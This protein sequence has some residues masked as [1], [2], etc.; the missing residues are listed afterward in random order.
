[1]QVIDIINKLSTARMEYQSTNGSVLNKFVVP[2]FIENLDLRNISHSVALVGSRGSGKSTYI[3]YF[4][5]ATRF[6]SDVANIDENELDCIL[7]Y[8]KPDIAYCQ[9]LKSNWLKE[10]ALLFFALHSSLSI[11]EELARLIDNLNIHYNDFIGSLNKNYTFWT[12]VSTITKTKINTIKGLFDWIDDYKYELSTRLN[13]VNTENLLSIQP[14]SMLKYLTDALRKD[15]KPLEKTVFKIFV[16]EFELLTIEQ[17]K[18]INTYRKESTGTLTWNVAYKANAKPSKD[19]NSDQ[20]LQSP[21]DFREVNIDDLIKNDYRIFA[22]EIFILTLRNAGLNCDIEEFSPTYLGARENIKFRR[23][24]SYRTSVL[25]IVSKILPTPSIKELSNNCVEINSV[26]TILK[27]ILEEI[28]FNAKTIQKIYKNPSIAITI[29]GT[30]KQKSFNAEL[31]E[32]YLCEST[33]ESVSKKVLQKIS[34][35]EFNTLLSLN[36]QH[37]AVNVPVYAGFERFVTMTTPNIRHFKELCLNALRYSQD[38][39]AEVNYKYIED[40]KSISELGMHDG[41][42]ATSSSLVKEVLSYP[43]Y[44]NRLAKMVNRI[45]ELFKISQKSSYQSEPERVIFTIP[46]DYAGSDEDLE[47]FLDSALSWRVL[48]ID[49]SKRIK[50]DNQITNKEYQLNPIYSPRFGISY[51]KKRGI[52][53]TVNE[54]KTII[55]GNSEEFESIKKSYQKRWRLDEEIPQQGILL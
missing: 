23:E 18:T 21:D 20:C 4:S 51:R 36:L 29:I 9:G 49:D 47:A 54:F 26:K 1:M 3:Q 22:A 33:S 43:P 14:N 6:D 2:Y 40:I 46:Y 50:D 12:R 17:Q 35:F 15:Y 10:K 52:T 19:T 30:H 37:T 27:N 38:I 13:P 45:G 32:N 11:L 44:G 31:W 48:I 7:L 5:H 28:G 24:E 25:A 34:T 16:D 53:L 8:W 39:D 41:A 55:S 42:I